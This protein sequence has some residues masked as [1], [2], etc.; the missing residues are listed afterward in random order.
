MSAA[1][2]VFL[3]IDHFNNAMGFLE[4]D[5]FHAFLKTYLCV[6]AATAGLLLHKRSKRARP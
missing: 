1:L 6:S 4:G 2:L 3:V 5:V